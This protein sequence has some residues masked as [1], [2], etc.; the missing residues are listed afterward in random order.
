MKLILLGAPEVE[1]IFG[2]QDAWNGLEKWLQGNMV[3]NPMS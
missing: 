3:V 1:W 2:L